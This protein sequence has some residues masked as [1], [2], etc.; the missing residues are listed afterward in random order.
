MDG[1]AYLATVTNYETMAV[2]PGVRVFRL[3]R[4]RALSHSI[5]DPHAGLRAIHVAGTK[6]KGSTSAMIA[7]ILRASGA[8]TG[9]FTSPHLMDLTER[10]QVN[11]ENIP[12]ADFNRLIETIKEPVESMRAV[13]NAPTFF[14]IITCVAFRYFVE[15]AVDFAVV[16][17]G[18]GELSIPPT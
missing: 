3:D 9:L 10:I 14:E 18:L 15:R 12:R 4:V 17:V 11:G 1:E 2:R 7:S 6:G 5:G 13:D 16:E 8:R